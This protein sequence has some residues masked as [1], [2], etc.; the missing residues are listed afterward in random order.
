M[1][2]DGMGLAGGADG[3]KAALRRRFPDAWTT[4]SDLHEVGKLTNAVP[5]EV[6]SVV[7]GNVA[8]MAVPQTITSLLDMTNFLVNQLAKHLEVAC[9]VVVVLDNPATLTRAKVAEQCRRDASRKRPVPTSSDLAPAF[10]DDNFL[11]SDLRAGEDIRAYIANR[12]TRMRIVDAVFAGVFR[13]LERKLAG[14]GSFSVVG[15]DARGGN[16]PIGERRRADAMSTDEHLEEALEAVVAGEG[17]LKL[18]E[19]VEVAIAERS[20]K[21][22]PLAGFK[23]AHLHTIDTDSILIELAVEARRMEEKKLVNTF[24]VFK[25]RRS[26]GDASR[27]TLLDL[28]GQLLFLLEDLFGLDVSKIAPGLVRPAIALFVMCQAAQGTDFCGLKG[29]RTLEILDACRVVCSDEYQYLSSLP[30]IW[31]GGEDDLRLAEPALRRV[32]SLCGSSL[33]TVSRRKVHASSLKDPAE[34][35]LLRVLWTARYWLGEEIRDV[36]GWGF[37]ALTPLAGGVGTK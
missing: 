21:G 12:A 2:S 17:D 27:F 26:P 7:D 14:S 29:L 33:E 24:V 32:L 1:T 35:A 10:S 28:T 9:N 20:R 16:R 30:S 18:S 8:A 25:E 13:A 6:L 19:V 34:E 22:S 31:K 36:R 11:T 4:A 37:G 5:A 15:C 3:P 23:T